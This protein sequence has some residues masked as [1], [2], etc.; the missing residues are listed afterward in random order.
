MTKML[1]IEELISEIDKI[2]DSEFPEFIFKP[3]GNSF[4]NDDGYWEEFDESD[5]RLKIIGTVKKR[6]RDIY[7]YLEKK[8]VYDEY[9]SDLLDKYG[10]VGVVGHTIDPGMIPEYVPIEPRLKMNRINKQILRSGVLPSRKMLDSRV[11]RNLLASVTEDLV[12]EAKELGVASTVHETDEILKGISDNNERFHEVSEAK[13]R[14]TRLEKFLR[15]NQVQTDTFD[16][17]FDY[18][19]QHGYFKNP[20]NET[21]FI[22]FFK[23]AQEMEELD[24]TPDFIL[25]ANEK[26]GQIKF[27]PYG[28][29]TADQE[30]RQQLIRDMIEGGFN[31]FE[32]LG[33]GQMSKA[34]IRMTKAANVGSLA[35]QTK[36]AKK[37]G[38][39]LK[40]IQ[41]EREKQMRRSINNSAAISS[42][43]GANRYELG[44]DYLSKDFSSFFRKKG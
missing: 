37:E 9:I 16:F 2:P 29:R 32:I 8:E 40:K 30:E 33:K 35:E 1:S 6:E 38:K 31:P 27:T 5:P 42:L 34:E 39:K 10:L 7:R 14:S 28:T 22:D 24:H 44:G 4:D 21:E 15:G 43:I 11:R 18:Y 36:R 26:R 23:V 3:M 13:R 25:R 12:E 41:K 17:M 19:N 20:D